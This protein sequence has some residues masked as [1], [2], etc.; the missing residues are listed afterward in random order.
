MIATADLLSHLC[1]CGET[2]ESSSAWQ[3]NAIEEK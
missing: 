2:G 1:L 3:E